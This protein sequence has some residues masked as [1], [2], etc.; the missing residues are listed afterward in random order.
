[1]IEWTQ[2]HTIRVT[3]EYRIPV[4]RGAGDRG[5]VLA[6]GPEAAGWG[7]VLAVREGLEPVY[8]MCMGDLTVVVRDQAEQVLGELRWHHFDSLSAGDG[9]LPLVDPRRL[10]QRLEQAR[11]LLVRDGGIEWLPREQWGLPDAV[12]IRARVP[13][14]ALAGAFEDAG[15]L[16]ER[17]G[18]ECRVLGEDVYAV[19]SQHGDEVL[20]SARLDGV[21]A[22]RVSALLH[23]VIAGAASRSR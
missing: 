15:W 5:V 7:E 13:L 2:A 16:V 3:R 18:R 17:R 19:L 21:P 4:K 22:E 8:C 12:E 10:I 1:M 11:V 9:T 23:R 6:R 14:W 20:I